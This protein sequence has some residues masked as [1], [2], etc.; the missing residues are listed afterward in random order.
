MNM[1]K[2]LIFL[3]PLIG[4]LCSSL[5][6]AQAQ[7]DTN[8]GAKIFLPWI[9]NGQTENLNMHPVVEQVSDNRLDPTLADLMADNA[10][11]EPISVIIWLNMVEPHADL[12]GP[13]DSVAEAEPVVEAAAGEA[14]TLEAEPDAAALQRQQAQ[15][16]DLTRLDEQR[17]ATVA[18]VTAP[19]LDRLHS[20]GYAATAEQDAPMIYA[21]LP[22]QQ[23]KEVATWAEVVLVT[24]DQI[25]QPEAE[26]VLPTAT[27]SGSAAAVVDRAKAWVWA[28]QPTT[29]GCYTPSSTYQFNSSRAAN[30]VCRVGSVGGGEYR[31]DLPGLGT[32]GGMVQVSAYG[33]NQ[34]CKVVSWF[35]TGT[36]QQVFVRCFGANGAPADGRF[37]LLFYKENR[38]STPESVETAAY[39]W[40]DQPRAASYT[41]SLAYQWNSKGGNNTIRRISQGRYEARLPGMNPTGG[42]V[43][44]TAYGTGSERCKVVSWILSGSDTL[45]YVNCFSGTQPVDTLYTLSYMKDVGLGSQVP[46]DQHYG[47]YLWAHDA[48]ATVC[49]KTSGLYQFNTTRAANAACRLAT[50]SYRLRLPALAP[51]NRT[52]TQV[53]ASGSGSEYCTVKSWSSDG[54]GGTYVFVKCFNAAGIAVNTRFTLLYLTDDPLNAG[55]KTAYVAD[56]RAH[57]VPIPPDWAETGTPWVLQGPLT[58]NLLEPGEFAGV[59]TY[60]D[61]SARG[62]CIALPRGTGNSGSLAGIICQSATTGHACFWDNKL[63]SDPGQQPIGWSGVRLVISQLHDGTSLSENCTSCHRGN[64]VFLISPDD[65]T[66]A[67]VLRGPLSGPSTGTFTTQVEKSS[68]EQGGHPRYIP[69]TT[70][71]ERPGWQNPFASGGCAGACHEFHALPVANPIPT[72]MPPD[73]ARPSTTDPSRC[74]G[75]P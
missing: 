50:G 68:D 37:T 62:A 12:F 63:R 46:E 56:C 71:P 38:V 1:L 70:L 44:V 4:L 24:L 30:R 14:M 53:T 19:I 10:N 8:A 45:A 75:T 2:K 26:L 67:K 15:E 23:I 34:H 39:L 40:A 29:A 21:S 28:N 25:S 61:P 22:P 33:G 36:T 58:Q 43:L 49:Y 52:T 18:L 55:S 42:T 32:T 13:T 59:W 66:W 31:V 41:P 54:R 47:G 73:C 72:P 48:T 3:L 20:L 60:S 74:Y 6:S 7:N 16:A 69:I 9:A 65:P 11:H 57:S 17:V 35:P 27:D 51:V 64:N 5:P